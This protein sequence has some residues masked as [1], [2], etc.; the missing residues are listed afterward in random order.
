MKIGQLWSSP[1]RGSILTD[2][3]LLFKIHDSR[4]FRLFCF[5]SSVADFAFAFSHRFAACREQLAIVFPSSSFYSSV[6]SFSPS[7]QHPEETRR[8]WVS[9]VSEK[10]RWLTRNTVNRTIQPKYRTYRLFLRRRWHCAVAAKTKNESVRRLSRF[11]RFATGTPASVARL[12]GVGVEGWWRWRKRRLKVAARFLV[13]D[14]QVDVK[15]FSSPRHSRCRSGGAPAIHLL[16]VGCSCWLPWNK[17]GRGSPAAA[18]HRLL[19]SSSV[20]GKIA[21]TFFAATFSRLSPRRRPHLL[22]AI[23]SQFPFFP[24]LSSFLPSSIHSPLF[25]FFFLF[26]SFTKRF[27]PCFVSS[28]KFSLL[29]VRRGTVHAPT[30]RPAKVFRT[31]TTERSWNSTGILLRESQP[32]KFNLATDCGP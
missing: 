10:L 8:S 12:R 24:F 20:R 3:Y 31:F 2:I 5:K 32:A 6:P 29:A 25:L 18:H 28:R 22:R 11:G 26:F 7:E 1:I 14:L 23:T 30:V 13:W 16:A 27:Q 9:G 17:C 4:L 15:L 21:L 19:S